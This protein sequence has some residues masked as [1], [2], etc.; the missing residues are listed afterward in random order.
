MFS[1]HILAKS[2]LQKYVWSVPCADRD[3][4]TNLHP[5]VLL[6]ENSMDSTQTN[7]LKFGQKWYSHR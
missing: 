5:C 1:I 4:N 6:R 2:S 7:Q 3:F